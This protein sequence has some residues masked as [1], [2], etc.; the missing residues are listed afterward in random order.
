MGSPQVQRWALLMSAYE[1][2]MV[3]KSKDSHANADALSRLPLLEVEQEQ[4][5]PAQ[6]LL[7]DMLEFERVSATQI[8]NW[9]NKDV[10]LSQVCYYVLKGWLP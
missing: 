1:Y 8:K 5:N 7:L 6:V 10:V 3:Y 4:G 2:T 9:T